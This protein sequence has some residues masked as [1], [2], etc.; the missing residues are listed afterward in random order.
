MGAGA[1]ES[2]RHARAEEARRR[3][4]KRTLEAACSGGAGSTWGGNTSMAPAAGAEGSG[5]MDGG[6]EALGAAESR[7]ADEGE[8]IGLN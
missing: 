4:L 7:V 6:E 3:E 8:S 2:R 1:K 5:E